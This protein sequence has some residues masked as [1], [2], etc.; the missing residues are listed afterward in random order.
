MACRHIN[1]CVGVYIYGKRFYKIKE[2]GRIFFIKAIVSL[3]YDDLYI[4]LFFRAA[5]CSRER[6]FT[7]SR[8]TEGGRALARRATETVA[9]STYKGRSLSVANENVFYPNDI[10]VLYFIFL[11]TYLCI[12]CLVV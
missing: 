2:E 1:T 12:T 9:A 7:T 11:H 4:F 3:L 5:V 6:L 8:V 10:S